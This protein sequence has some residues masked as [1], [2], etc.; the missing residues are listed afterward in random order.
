ML[1]VKKSCSRIYYDK[2]S[3]NEPQNEIFQYLDKILT[4]ETNPTANFKVFIEHSLFSLK[5]WMFWG[6]LI[7]IHVYLTHLVLMVNIMKLNPFD[8]LNICFIFCTMRNK[9]CTIPH[10]FQQILSIAQVL[11][12]IN[13][14]STELLLSLKFA[15]P[16]KKYNEFLFPALIS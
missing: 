15:F 1:F 13:F 2:S 9:T 14:V 12:N 11:G 10:V 16:T 3:M 7:K 5:I 4:F 8:I 6:D